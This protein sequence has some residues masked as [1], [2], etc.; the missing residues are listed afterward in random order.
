MIFSFLGAF[1]WNT[2][3]IISLKA[4]G[5]YLDHFWSNKIL[6]LLC[7]GRK[8]N[9]FMISEFLTPGDPCLWI[10]IYQNTS[11]NIRI[12]MDTFLHN[13]YFVNMRIY[14]WFLGKSMYHD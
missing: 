4:P 12:I 3:S 9:I 2:F 11:N 6:V 14:F 8:P 7:E 10:L 1:V 5:N 13:N